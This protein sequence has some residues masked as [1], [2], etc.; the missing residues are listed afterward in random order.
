MLDDLLANR[1]PKACSLGL[2]GQGVLTQ[3]G[4]FF[5]DQVKVFFSNTDPGVL[6]TDPV[7]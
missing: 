7:L 1:Q 6:N 4:E 2:V 3:L 5:K